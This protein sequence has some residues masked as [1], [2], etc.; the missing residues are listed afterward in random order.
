MWL[1]DTACH[2]DPN[3]VFTRL[4]ESEGVLLHLHTKRYYSVNETGAR[5]W[6]LLQERPQP[7]HIATAFMEEYVIEAPQALAAVVSFIDRLHQAGLVG[8]QAPAPHGS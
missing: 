6:E 7:H 8:L 2:P 3:V 4:G 5:L 1:A